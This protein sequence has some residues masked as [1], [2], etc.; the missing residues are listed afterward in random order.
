[1][2]ARDKEIVRELAKRYMELA[3]DEKQQDANRRMQ[4]TNDLKI[5]RPPVLIDESPWFEMDIYT[6]TKSLNSFFD[7][8]SFLQSFSKFSLVLHTNI[9]S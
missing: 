2:T 5:V 4:D 3:T 6:D 8:L 9:L 7:A 1:M